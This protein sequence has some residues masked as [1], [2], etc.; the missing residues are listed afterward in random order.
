MSAGQFYANGELDREIVLSRVIDAPV[1]IVF[2]AWTDPTRL[3]Q[4][5]GPR[6][7]RCEVREQADAKRLLS[8]GRAD[9]NGIGPVRRHCVPLS[10]SRRSARRCYFLS[11]RWDSSSLSTLHNSPRVMRSR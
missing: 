8:S 3:F 11:L 4:W 5:F 1:A 6:G 2:R 10:P 9:A 7:F